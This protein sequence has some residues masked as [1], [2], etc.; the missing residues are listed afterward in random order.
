MTYNE[1]KLVLLSLEIL[2][3]MPN[4]EDVSARK[5]NKERMEKEL[6]KWLKRKNINDLN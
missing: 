1:T 5:K 4:L 6:K 3:P 2:L